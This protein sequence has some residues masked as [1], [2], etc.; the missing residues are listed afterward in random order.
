MLG[1]TRAGAERGDLGR[2]EGDGAQHQ[3]HRQ[4]RHWIARLHAVE[5]AREEPRQ[6]A[7]G[8][9]SDRDS[10]IASRAVSNTTSLRTTRGEAP[11]ASRTPFWGLRCSTEYAINPYIPTDASNKAA[12][13]KNIIN[14]AFMRVRGGFRCDFVQPADACHRQASAG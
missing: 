8:K 6:P 2:D 14:N 13:P 5:K 4:E 9:G 11:S 1:S 3:R 12:Q 10:T 7:C